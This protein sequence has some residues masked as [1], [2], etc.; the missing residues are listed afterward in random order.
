MG[1]ASE[2]QKKKWLY[3]VPWQTGRRNLSRKFALLSQWCRYFRVLKNRDS[4]HLSCYLCRSVVIDQ[5]NT[6]TYL[7][8]YH[9]LGPEHFVWFLLQ[10]IG[11]AR[12]VPRMTVLAGV[13][14][15]R[16]VGEGLGGAH[17]LSNRVI[18]ILKMLLL[19]SVFLGLS[20]PTL[21]H[22]YNPW[23]RVGY[24]YYYHSHFIDGEE[25]R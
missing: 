20:L 13:K 5:K 11:W 18:N 6:Y 15:G 23:Q 14:G 8:I 25:W 24:H 10:P 3:N 1:E 9:T 19:T 4:R 17:Q 22:L 2:T 7:N 21:Y 12:Q 16:R